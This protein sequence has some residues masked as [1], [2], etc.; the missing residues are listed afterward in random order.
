M[1]TQKIASVILC[2]SAFLCFNVEK[3]NAFD[4]GYK[5]IFEICNG[6]NYSEL[7][8]DLIDGLIVIPVSINGGEKLNFILDTGT[9]SPI[10]LNKKYVKNLKLPLSR[11]MSFQGA[12]NGSLVSGRV[13]P[14]MSLQVGDAI[15]AHIG[16][17]LLDK[18]PLS[19][20]VIQN[21]KIHGV[22]GATL[23]RSFAVEIDYPTHTIRLHKN[24]AFLDKN[25]YSEHEMKIDSSRP[26]VSVEVKTELGELPLSLMID[27]GFNNN[28]LLYDPNQQ[29]HQPGKLQTIGKG[30]SGNIKATV[31]QIKSIKLA[32]RQIFDVNTYFPSNKSY[33][34]SS[35]EGYDQRDGII[36]NKLL[37]QFCIVFD[38]AHEKLYLQEH[39]LNIPSSLAKE[40]TN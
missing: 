18:N 37:L 32:D 4:S 33:K 8:F 27:T 20:L 34:K 40:V 1:K 39:L 22:I 15:A 25:L 26:V 28:L 16:G 7:T 19:N 10:I 3:A 23:F 30:Y 2:I 6:I 12:G 24:D 11:T 21:K 17:V 31:R 29:Y 38:Y 35:D 9:R 36:G 5:G 14:I 13:V